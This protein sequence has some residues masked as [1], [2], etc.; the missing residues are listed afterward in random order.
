MKINNYFFFVLSMLSLLPMNGQIAASKIVAYYGFNGNVQ[1]NS[2]GGGHNATN[3]GATLTTDRNGYT[4]SA[5]YFDG[6]SNYME[7]PNVASSGNASRSISAWI[8]TS[9]LDTPMCFLSTGSGSLTTGGTFNLIYG[10]NQC[11]FGVMGFFNDFYPSKGTSLNDGKWHHIC[12]V[13]NGTS[14]NTYVDGK[15]DNSGSMTY[16]TVSQVNFIGR[17]NDYRF[18]QYFKGAM[19][20]VYFYNTALSALQVDSLFKYKETQ[21]EMKTEAPVLSLGLHPNP[22]QNIL[23]LS[24][25]N[26]TGNSSF[27]NLG[28]FDMTG[29]QVSQQQLAMQSNISL[30]MAFLA[31]GT[32]YFTVMVDKNIFRSKVVKV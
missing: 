20:D 17:S 4:N 3:H 28:I 29:K 24:F 1:D 2:A 32:Y 18:Y 21:S 27:L 19:D 23:N 30:D 16:N 9:R 5:Y 15:L 12:V 22:M 7:M 11:K 6:K 25:Q 31:A 14:I 8:K 10:Y 13:F 26:F